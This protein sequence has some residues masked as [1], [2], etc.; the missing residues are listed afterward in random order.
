MSARSPINALRPYRPHTYSGKR[1]PPVDFLMRRLWR[2]A[3]RKPT[4][5]AAVASVSWLRRI[6]RRLYTLLIPIGFRTYIS[7]VPYAYRHRRDR[8]GA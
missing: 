7:R 1:R 8:R 4:R 3:F 5:V 6:F 2:Q